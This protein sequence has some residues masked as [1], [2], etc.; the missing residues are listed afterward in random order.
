MIRKHFSKK[1]QRW[2][3]MLLLLFSFKTT[4]NAAKIVEK[5]IDAPVYYHR[6]QLVNISRHHNGDIFSTKGTFVYIM[7]V[8]NDVRIHEVFLTFSFIFLR[9]SKIQT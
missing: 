6:D 9:I 8:S 2:P 4:T 1:H 5:L 3:L 7:L